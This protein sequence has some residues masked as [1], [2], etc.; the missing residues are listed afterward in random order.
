MNDARSSVFIRG[1]FAC[2]ALL[3]VATVLSLTL[4][5]IWGVRRVWPHAWAAIAA[6]IASSI[7]VHRETPASVGL[8]FG[9]FR[10]AARALLPVVTAAAGAILLAGVATNS[11]RDVDAR[12]ATGGLVLYCF[13]GLFQQYLLNGFVVNRLIAAGVRRRAPAVAAIIFAIVHLPN[14]FLVLVALAGGYA[15]AWGYLRYRNLMIL[16]LAH[17]VV[18]F[19]LYFAVPDSISHHLYVGPK[20]IAY[21]R[22]QAR[23]SDLSAAAKIFNPAA[24]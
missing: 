19:A 3:E 18:G 7:I 21:C 15:S 22:E 12:F 5:Y 6:L 13:W 10:P 4:L 20:C 16:G 9:A 8:S 2:G 11:I 24:W 23:A 17:G 1:L 14:P